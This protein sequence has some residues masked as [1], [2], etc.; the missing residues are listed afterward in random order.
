MG[1]G[2]AAKRRG[3]RG[4][5]RARCAH[6]IAEGVRGAPAPPRSARGRCLRGAGNHVRAPW[7]PPPPLRSLAPRGS[8][9]RRSLL[10]APLSPPERGVRV[11][12]PPAGLLRYTTRRRRLPRSGRG[13]T[14]HVAGLRLRRR[15]PVRR[16]GT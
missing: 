6:L 9:A 12:S 8:G 11:A 7:V 13:G 10:P 1:S 16:P 5:R 4:R 2:L 3:S 15:R 14:L